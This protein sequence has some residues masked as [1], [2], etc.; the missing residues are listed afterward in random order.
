MNG[1]PQLQFPKNEQEVD[2][3]PGTAA[4]ESLTGEL[5]CREI[6]DIPTIIGGKKFYS[7]DIEEVRAPHDRGRILARI[8]RPAESQYREAIASAMTAAGE[9]AALPFQY[10]AAVLLRAAELIAGEFRMRINAATM[11]GQSKTIDQA[12]PDSACELID[13]LRFNVYYAQRLHREQPLS[14]QDAANRI[15]WRPLEGFVYAISPFNFTAIG[16]NLSTA[17]ALMGN[18]VLWKPSEKSSLANYIFYEAL[19]AAGLPPGV[20]NFVP[21][22]AIDL[23]QAVLASP[24]LAGIHFTGSTAVF[25]GIWAG[26]GANMSAYRTFPRL[27]GETGGKG[28]VLA[29]PSADVEVLATAMIKGAF[30]FQ[31]Q[32]CSA[33]SRAYIPK[34]L[35]PALQRELL[36]RLSELKV[37]DVADPHTFMGAVIDKTSYDRLA[38][39][40][41]EARVDSEVKI[42]AGG[43]ATEE[44]GFFIQP[45]VLEVENPHHALMEVELFGPLLSVFVYDDR[46]WPEILTVIDTTSPYALTGSIFATDPV[47]LHAA[48][49]ALFNSAGNLYLNDKPTGAVIGQQ[50]FGGMRASGTND[51]AG[52]W[53]NLLRWTSPR[54]VKETYL[55]SKR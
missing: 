25:R 38:H 29:H 1:Q 18:V 17:P 8:H 39:R 23:T 21:A 26:V 54:T 10:R 30:E 49:Q 9:W 19:Q 28:F 15:D 7:N 16:A 34:S 24:H 11:L 14:V 33:A 13:F 36:D 45:T 22:N 5:D 50:P 31:G 6:I 40:L 51:K 42:I 55:P 2:Y 20:I 46:T 53:M 32:K 35:W 37:G 4:F 52:S 3:Q 47:A 44:T 27:V 12:E 41:A 48:E 43:G